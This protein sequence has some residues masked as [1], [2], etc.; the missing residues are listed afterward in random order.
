MRPGGWPRGGPIGDGMGA[1]ALL[2]LG[3]A[4]PARLGS[5]AVLDRVVEAI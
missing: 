5:S 4:S 2:E 1:E 3:L